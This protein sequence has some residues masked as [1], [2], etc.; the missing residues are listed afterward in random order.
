MNS[1]E[2]CG[3]IVLTVTLIERDNQNRNKQNRKL[4]VMFVMSL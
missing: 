4:N 2:G 1:Y 3:Q